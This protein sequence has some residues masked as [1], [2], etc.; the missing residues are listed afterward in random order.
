MANKKD[1][2]PAEIFGYPIGNQSNEVQ[3]ARRK[4][5]CPFREE[6]CTKK[7][8][9]IEY[10]FRVCSVEYDGGIRTICPHRFEES[11]STDGVAQV[12]EDIALHHFGNTDNIVVFPEVGLPNV[13]N[14]DYVII[15]HKPMQAV[16]DEFIAVEFQSDSTTGTGELVRGICDFYEEYDLQSQSYKFGMNTYD[17]IKRAITQLMNKGIVYEA[18]NS[19]CYW[20]IQE[21]IYD[22][23]VAR[24]GLKKKG[25]SSQHASVFALY[26][27]VTNGDCLTLKH[28]RFISTTVRQIYQAM[29]NNSAMPNKDRFVKTLNKKLRL[30]LCVT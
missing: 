13:G 18:W 5:W 4:Y 12:L 9:L 14:I 1:K 3:N 26:D 30:K 7:S 20:V 11:S 2:R 15:K 27:M 21:Y 29:R 24:Y 10:P 6:Q 23:L 16:V 28:T 25:F 19:K 17:S 22:N 8:R